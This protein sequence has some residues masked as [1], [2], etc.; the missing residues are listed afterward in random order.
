MENV[1]K[2][3]RL[4]EELNYIGCAKMKD[5]HWE[6][7]LL[8]Y[9][10]QMRGIRALEKQCNKNLLKTLYKQGWIE[11]LSDET[12]KVTDLGYEDAKEIT[13]LY[14]SNHTQVGQTF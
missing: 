5:S 9:Q 8:I 1:I 6:L 13:E 2:V 7:L 3:S 10:D 4:F 11:K 12:I 14:E